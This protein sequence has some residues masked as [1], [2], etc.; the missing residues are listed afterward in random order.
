MDKIIKIMES[1]KNFG[2]LIKG[3]IKT[4]KNEAKEQ[5]G[6]FIGTL[7]GTLAA[8]ILENM[9]AEKSKIPWQGVIRTSEG[10]IWVGKATARAGQNF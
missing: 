2:L 8:R 9:S 6:G 1:L 3:V 7:L 10:V 5:E 4:I